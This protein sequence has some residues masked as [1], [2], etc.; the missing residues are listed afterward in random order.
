[1]M[2]NVIVNNYEMHYELDDFTDPW[3]KEKETIVIQHALGRKATFCT[4]WGSRLAPPLPR[5]SPRHARTRAVGRPRSESC[6]VGRRIAHGHK[7]VPGCTE[8][9]SRPFCRRIDRG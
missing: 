5:D 7:R 2:P 6:V 4:T 1:N 3:V 9:R 8:S